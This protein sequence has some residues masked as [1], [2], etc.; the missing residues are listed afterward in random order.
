MQA[1]ELQIVVVEE[2]R[3]S[4]LIAWNNAPVAELRRCMCR[5]SELFDDD[6]TGCATIVD[7]DN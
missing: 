2:E 4:A 1:A 6:Q 3:L 5:P 7:G